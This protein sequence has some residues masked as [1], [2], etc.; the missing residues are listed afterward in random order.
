M[1]L[2][3]R[4]VPIL[5]KFASP[6]SC[7]MSDLAHAVMAKSN[8]PSCT[9]PECTQTQFYNNP[10]EYISPLILLAPI[11][12]RLSQPKSSIYWKLAS[13]L[14]FGVSMLENIDMSFMPSWPAMLWFRGGTKGPVIPVA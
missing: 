1:C 9:F 12:S 13:L 2:S 7:E 6:S 4:I 8:D 5:V 11:V 3:L 14:E 10:F